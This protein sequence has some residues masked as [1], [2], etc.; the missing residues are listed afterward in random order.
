MADTKSN[1]GGKLM[2]LF[3][4]KEKAPFKQPKADY[5]SSTGSYRLLFT[6]SFTGEKNLGELGPVK[7]YLPAYDILSLRSWQSYFESEISQIVY[8]R[9]TTWVIGSGLKLQA[10]PGWKILK[11][12]GIK[13]D[14]QEF[15]SVVESRFAIYRKSS[16]CDYSGENNLDSIASTVFKNAKIG[17]DCLVVLRYQNGTVNIQVIDGQHIQSPVYGTEYFPH[18]LPNGNRV[19]NG[20]EVDDKDTVIA[21]YVRAWQQP[22]Q[23]FKYE[24]IP[25]K[26]D[27]TGLTVAFLVYG[28]KYRIDNKRG[29]PVTSS[30]LETMKK[31]ERYKEATVASA[32]ERAKIPYFIEHGVTSTGQNPLIQ[33]IAKAHDID[34]VNN[35]NLP[36]SID[37]EELANTVAATT[38]KSV[39]N[40]PIDSKLVSLESKNELHFKEFYGVN[41]DIVCASVMMPPNVAMSKYETSFSSSR[42]ALKDWEHTLKVQRNDFQ[43]QFYQ[44]VYNFWL[45]IEVLKNKI[46]SPGYLAAH[47]SKD[48][49]VTGAYQNCRFVGAQVPHIDPLKEVNAER[50][51]LGAA[52]A[53]LPLTTLEAATENLSSGES[54][55]N[56]EQFAIELENG[57]KLKIVQP[58]PAPVKVIPPGKED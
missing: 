31:L 2:A 15:C 1:I 34:N 21:Y 49:M 44:R 56:M 11:A 47:K 41:V 7:N 32:E 20:V 48:Y 3:S 46:P 40:M 55:S 37:G 54:E 8:N 58:I 24:R 25:A 27:E 13:I 19:M 30:V 5:S 29:M 33:S 12:E 18:V 45:L 51:K 4:R 39:F 26:S 22:N 43:N 23:P 16:I 35:E 6:T 38:E 9:L 52:G 57:K 10:E 36:K 14:A 50:E 17:G 42:A 28:S 53:D